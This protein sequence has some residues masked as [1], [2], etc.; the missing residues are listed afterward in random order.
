MHQKL[1]VI[2]ASTAFKNKT[3]WATYSYGP[4]YDP[5]RIPDL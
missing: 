1:V 5:A 4:I 2:L 3:I